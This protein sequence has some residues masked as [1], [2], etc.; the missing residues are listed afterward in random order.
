LV[1]GA[2]GD[3]QAAADCYARAAVTF[4][5]SDNRA[6]RATAYSN[7]AYELFMLGDIASA[8]E[9]GTDALRLS[10]DIGN[11]LT[12]ADVHHTLG[13]IAEAEGER[14]TAREHAQAAIGEFDLAGMP[15]AGRA[16]HELADRNAGD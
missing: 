1:K 9:L 7:R 10:G 8:R 6:G 13:L 11:H 12:A 4:E 2:Q 15:G 16:S 5:R 14:R 3:H